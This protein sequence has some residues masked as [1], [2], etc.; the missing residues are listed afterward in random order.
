MSAPVQLGVVIPL[1]TVKAVGSVG[2]ERYYWIL[3][4]HGTVSMMPADVV[5]RWA[6]QRKGLRR[7]RKEGK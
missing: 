3:D 2:G 1:G 4:K 6:E 5:E 7:E